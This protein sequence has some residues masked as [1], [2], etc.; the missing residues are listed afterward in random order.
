M[1]KTFL[2]LIA[3]G[4]LLALILAFFPVSPFVASEVEEPL[5]APD[6]QTEFVAPEDLKFQKMKFLI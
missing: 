4:I 2:R 6:L 1:K 5:E 3:S